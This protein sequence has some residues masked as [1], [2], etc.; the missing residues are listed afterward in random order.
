MDTVL[1]G[2][3]NLRGWVAINCIPTAAHT[4]WG[5]L[6]GKIL[7]SN[8]PALKKAMIIAVAGVI[9]LLI[10]YSMDWSG[11]TPIIKRISTSSFV[12]ASGGWCLIA[13]ALCYWLIDIKGYKRGVVFF[14]IV[15]MN[16]IFIYMFS[17][18]VGQQWF[19]GFIAIFSNGFLRWLGVNLGIIH[20]INALVVLGLEWYICYWLY[21]KRIFIKI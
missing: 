11:L 20:V 3:I 18:T 12:I 17:E 7:I 5:V 1:M 21:K 19:N 6:V 2:K 14:A 16:P 4:I 8:Q 13:L 9:G 15:G 10:G